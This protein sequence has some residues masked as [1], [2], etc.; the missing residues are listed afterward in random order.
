MQR[1]S[2]QS[3]ANPISQISPLFHLRRFSSVCGRMLRRSNLQLVWGYNCQRMFTQLLNRRAHFT[4]PPA[5]WMFNRGLLF[6]LN[7]TQIL[8]YPLGTVGCDVAHTQLHLVGVGFGHEIQY[9]CWVWPS[10]SQA[11]VG[12][13]TVKCG[14]THTLMFNGCA[15]AEFLQIYCIIKTV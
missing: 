6:F 4:V 15:I 12:F 2:F 10:H 13:H 9:A 1:H 5:L 3:L 8:G 11:W 7:P 14:L